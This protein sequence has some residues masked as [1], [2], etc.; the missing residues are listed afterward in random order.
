[1]PGLDN[2]VKQNQRGAERML[3]PS[4]EGEREGKWIVIDSGMFVPH[5][6]DL[7]L[8]LVVKCKPMHYYL[9]LCIRIGVSRALKIPQLASYSCY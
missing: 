8:W 1:M 3:L 9:L 6:I 7:L 2:Q 4:V 5:A